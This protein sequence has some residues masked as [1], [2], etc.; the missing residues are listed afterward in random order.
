ML[1]KSSLK[2]NDET[3]KDEGNDK[4][5]LYTVTLTVPFGRKVPEKVV[6]VRPNTDKVVL[7]IDH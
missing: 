5:W 7:T 4:Q 2:L 6:E 1:K 3:T